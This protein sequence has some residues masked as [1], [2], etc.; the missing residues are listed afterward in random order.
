MTAFEQLPIPRPGLPSYL[1]TFRIINFRKGEAYRQSA[2]FAL[3]FG[4]ARVCLLNMSRQA[5]GGW[6]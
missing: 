4:N 5:N 2:L 1:L 6:P 3:C